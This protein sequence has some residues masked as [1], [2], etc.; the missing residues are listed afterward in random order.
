MNKCMNITIEAKFPEG[1]LQTKIVKYARDN[2][3]EGVGQKS[4]ESSVKIL[5]C[6]TVEALDN[7]LDLLHKDLAQLELQSFDVVPFLKDRDYRGVFRVI[8]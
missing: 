4:G 1:Y 7:F 8:E 6:G 3:L 2:H 5:I